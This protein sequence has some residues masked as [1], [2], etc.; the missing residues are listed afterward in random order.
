MKHTDNGGGQKSVSVDWLNGFSEWSYG[1]SYRECYE[2]LISKA[3][4]DINQL[5]EIQSLIKGRLDR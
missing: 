5:R 1:D 3:E 2:D 4:R